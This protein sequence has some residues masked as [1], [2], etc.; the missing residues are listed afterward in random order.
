MADFVVI[1][2][3]LMVFC[4]MLY[5]ACFRPIILKRKEE[6]K[7]NYLAKIDTEFARLGQNLNNVINTLDE[8]EAAWK[9]NDSCPEKVK[10]WINSIN[11]LEISITKMIE[12]LQSGSEVVEGLPQG[13]RKF[14]EA[15]RVETLGRAKKMLADV[16]ELDKMTK[17]DK[18]MMRLY[19]E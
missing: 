9:L 10:S 1:G 14:A 16:S 6:Q 18:K 19:S 11:E 4:S 15:K 12:E 17:S 5:L 7:N 3:M 8:I 2:T 13:Q